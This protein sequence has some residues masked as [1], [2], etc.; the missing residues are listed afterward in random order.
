[1]VK[2]YKIV[3]VFFVFFFTC[4][5]V[6]CMQKRESLNDG[7]SFGQKEVMLL[8]PKSVKVSALFDL[9][10]TCKVNIDI[11]ECDVVRVKKNAVIF[12]SKFLVLKKIHKTRIFEVVNKRPEKKG[13]GVIVFSD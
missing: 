12:L 9:S 7:F 2:N 1:M 10:K 11:G 5:I 8:V 6:Y 4:S 3:L 13:K